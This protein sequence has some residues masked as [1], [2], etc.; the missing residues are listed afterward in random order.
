MLSPCAPC[1]SPR[2]FCFSPSRRIPTGDLRRIDAYSL[3]SRISYFLWGSMPDE[4]LFDLA[5]DGKLH[6]PEVVARC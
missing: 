4:L 3:A 5:A 2:D 1:W 6:E